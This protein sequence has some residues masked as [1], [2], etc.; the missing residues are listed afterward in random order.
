MA[1]SPLARNVVLIVADDMG[2]DTRAYGNTY[3]QTPHLDRLS[4]EGVTFRN[5]FCT[6]ASCSASRSTLLTGLQGHATGQYGL[7]HAEHNF[8]SLPSTMSLPK[9]LADRG[10]RTAIVG[11]H[12]V[13]PA[14]LYAFQTTIGGMQGGARNPVAMAE[15]SRDFI[16]DKSA[17]FFLYFCPTDP[18]RSGGVLTNKPGRPNAF[19]NGPAYEGV[20]EVRYDPDKIQLPPWLPDTLAARAEWAEYCQSSSRVDQGV[21]RL[22]AILKETGQLEETLVIFLS[23]NGPP[24]PG[25]KTTLYDGGMR[26]PLIV[27]APSLAQ[28]GR[29]AEEMVSWV[30]ITPTILDWAGAE[31]RTRDGVGSEIPAARQGVPARRFHGRSFLGLLGGAAKEGWDVVY[32]SHT[33][34]EVTMYYPM[35][36]IRTLNHKLILN[37][38]WQLPYPFASDLFD[39]ATWQDV[40]AGSRPLYGPWKVENYLQRP[41]YELY[42]LRAD[43]HESNNLAINPSSADAELLESL[44]NRLK[45]Y[46]QATRD[47]WVVKYVHE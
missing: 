31:L 39:S 8:R 43:P 14:A 1:P 30:D 11:K 5:A 47:P 46:Q 15:R 32:G 20:E 37:L 22:M 34:H 36:A 7:S 45:A 2:R 44:A 29:M 12:H 6:T 16:A 40:L 19:A 38:A 26:L 4:V 23:D 3:I 24:F 10:Y 41:K 9:L 27:R 42:D 28:P 25:A 13:E 17:P 18:H 21:G 33:F 35:R